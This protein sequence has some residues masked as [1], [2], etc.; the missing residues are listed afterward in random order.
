MGVPAAWIASFLQGNPGDEHRILEAYAGE[1]AG[2]GAEVIAAHGGVRD[3]S[4]D[5]AA[6]GL[7]PPPTA[8]ATGAGAPSGLSFSGSGF[9]SLTTLIVLAVAA[10]AAWYLIRKR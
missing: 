10:A 3:A 8:L 6:P 4:G 5:Y 2:K 1:A 7:P 9:P